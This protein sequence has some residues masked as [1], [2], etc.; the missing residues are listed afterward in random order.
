MYRI[1]RSPQQ[2][3]VNEVEEDGSEC[4]AEVSVCHVEEEVIDYVGPE[5]T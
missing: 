2:A 5:L 1:R 3:I 4:E